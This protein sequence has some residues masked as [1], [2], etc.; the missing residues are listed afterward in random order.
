MCQHQ[1]GVL[2]QK[3]KRKKEYWTLM[4]ILEIREK[5]NAGSRQAMSPQRRNQ[6]HQKI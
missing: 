1:N 6:K 3:K 5:V 2:A 4:V